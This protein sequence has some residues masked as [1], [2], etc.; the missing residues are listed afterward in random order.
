[1]DLGVVAF[2][3]FPLTILVTSDIIRR[4]MDVSKDSV[5]HWLLIFFAT[6]DIMEGS[7][8]KQTSIHDITSKM[9]AL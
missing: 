3:C 2:F 4:E 1:M 6:E 5:Y 7:Y 9:T 8:R